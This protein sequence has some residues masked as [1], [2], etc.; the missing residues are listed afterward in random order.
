[1]RQ[2]VLINVAILTMDAALLGIEYASIFVLETV[3]KGF[4]YSVKLKI[5]FA[6]L[7]RLVKFVTNDKGTE[8]EVPLHHPSV[9]H[10]LVPESHGKS[11]PEVPATDGLH[12]SNTKQSDVDKIYA[13]EL[14]VE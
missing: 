13:H 3:L 6:I 1:M 8:T 9:S 2:L 10:V 7:S 5:E 12:L 11:M 14:E 4:L